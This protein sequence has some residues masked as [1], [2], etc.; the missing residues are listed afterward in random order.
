MSGFSMSG[1]DLRCARQ[2]SPD[3]ITCPDFNN[4]YW[5]SAFNVANGLRLDSTDMGW[6]S[7]YWHTEMQWLACDAALQLHGGA[8]CMNEYQIA[9]IWRDARVRR[10]YGGTSEI[11][12]E[13]IGRSL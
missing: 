10:I 5:P 2:S 4:R 6:V 13:M 9:Q 11:M 3:V 7:Q 1:R 8:G 12:G